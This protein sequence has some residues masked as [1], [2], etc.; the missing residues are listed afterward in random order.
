MNKIFKVTLTVISLVTILFILFNETTIEIK[1]L[2]IMSMIVAI[3]LT[4][5]DHNPSR[6]GDY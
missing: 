6:L 4:W 5:L 2:L 1:L 3:V